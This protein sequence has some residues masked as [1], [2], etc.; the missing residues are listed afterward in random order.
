MK[1]VWRKSVLA[2]MGSA[3]AFSAIFLVESSASL[4]LFRADSAACLIVLDVDM[5]LWVFRTTSRAGDCR[6]VYIQ[7]WNHG[8][9]LA[10]EEL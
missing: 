5:W 10:W 4:V 7:L 9:G 2:A 3:A 1:G 8:K 6:L